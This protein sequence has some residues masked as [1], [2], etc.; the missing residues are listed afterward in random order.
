MRSRGAGTC[1]IAQESQASTEDNSKDG[2]LDMI[3]SI[4]VVR[5]TEARKLRRH[6]R[7]PDS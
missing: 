7:A 3:S 1:A 4:V 6:L 2:A 5:L